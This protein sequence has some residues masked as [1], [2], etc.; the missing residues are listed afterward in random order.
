MSF[1]TSLDAFASLVMS[2][3]FK[4]KQVAFFDHYCMEF[5]D[6][7]ENKLSYT[8]IHKEYETQVEAQI[9]EA[10]GEDQFQVLLSG[11]EAWQQ[12]GG[13]Q[14]AESEAIAEAVDV[15]TSLSDFQA[16]KATMLGKRAAKMAQHTELEGFKGLI[17]V[18]GALDRTAEL[19]AAANE[20][21]GW[22]LIVEE[23][24]CVLY[25]KPG[26]DGD[27]YMRYSVTID[28][29]AGH[30]F[31]CMMD[32][33]EES[34]QWRDKV[35]AL[36]TI[37]DYGPY[38]K[39]VRQEMDLPWALRYIMSVADGYTIRFV[40]RADWPSESNY[41]YAV[42]PFDVETNTC[43]ESQGMLKIKSGVI[44][45]HPQDPSQSVLTGMDL[46]NLGMMPSWGLGFLMKKLSLPQIA[47]MV[48]NYK[49]VKGL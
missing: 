31:E 47:A 12:S 49:K 11:L 19:T 10:L 25:T 36:R 28:L 14:V 9:A 18:D 34:M 20:A 26:P 45:P 22:R 48:A 40:G 46:A 30:L 1:E 3:G 32:V 27:T 43:V 17:T 23:P 15:L 33:S 38:D 8:A 6:I 35:K 2:E 13:A 39:V 41:S 7:E 24:N 37:H 44:S 21:D 16:F 4:E 29:A 5:D 42:I